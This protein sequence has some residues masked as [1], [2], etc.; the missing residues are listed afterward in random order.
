MAQVTHSTTY[1]GTFTKPTVPT[2]P[3]TLRWT[4]HDTHAF[5]LIGLW[6]LVTR[7][8]W[9]NSATAQGTPIFDEKHYVPQAWDMVQS[10]INPLIG[11]I[12][13]NPGYGLVVHPPLAKQIEAIGE[14]VFG[15]TP[16]GWRFM[17]ALFGSATILLIMGVAR[18]ITGST[19]VATFAGLLGLFDGVLLIAS[20][21][22]MLDIFQTFF[23]VAAAYCLIRDFNQLHHRLH[24]AWVAG[25]LGTSAY[26]PRFG[27][28][29][30]RFAAG[31]NLGL[32]LS[33]KWS[34]LYYMAFFGVMSVLFD[35]YLRRKYKIH[36]PI[37][38]MLV[39]DAA[40]AFASIVLVPIA[41]YA[42]SWRAWFS[43]ETA[44]YRHA[45]TDGTITAD[46][47]LNKLPDTLASWLYYHQSVLEFHASLTTSA[48][49]VHPWDSKPW[50]WLVA[51]RPILYFSATDIECYAGTCRRMI[52]L[53]G[54]PA[55]WWLTVPVLVWTTWQVIAT[56]NI[57]MSIPLIAFAAG[58]LPWLIGYD[59]QMYFFY[60]TPLVP[61]TIIMIAYV[62]GTL[63]G[64]G[65]LIHPRLLP[66]PIHTGSVAVTTYLGLV[67]AMFVYFS[68]ILYG[69]PVPDSVYESL[70]WLP[71]WR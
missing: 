62:L 18:Q 37:R 27:F 44:V 2:T 50:T 45:A 26:G 21:Y 69:Y 42:W 4:K 29:W 70:M 56:K 65:R 51:G 61:F 1:T 71:S 13:S 36:R 17:A 59:R 19:T 31:I 52:Y 34:G 24:A 60:A 16:L 25:R 6:A 33:V 40:A 57:R 22:G 15:Y 23:I 8:A 49:H 53:F 43:S 3:K 66:A 39:R 14:L 20:R 28:R 67:L 35:V 12:E 32:A 46:S 38:G 48:G 58:F 10:W 11:G 30:W 64:R 41:V 7:F 47:W 68:P 55:I 9:L 54:T 5:T 63:L